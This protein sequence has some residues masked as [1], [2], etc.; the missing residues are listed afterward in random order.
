MF[1]KN[2]SK[3]GN[4]GD[5]G[6]FEESISQFTLN[7]D[8]YAHLAIEQA[9]YAIP[10]AMKESRKDGFIALIIAVDQLE[11][12]AVAKGALDPE[13]EAYR[14]DVKKFSQELKPEA[15][16]EELRQAKIANYKLRL[17]MG[18]MFSGSLSKGEL[19]V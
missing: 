17:L 15:L 3:R 19:P 18:L 7:P 6:H 13:D 1:L 5:V 11:N 14:E 4:F 12:I 2:K 9:I 8:Y 16:G 10:N